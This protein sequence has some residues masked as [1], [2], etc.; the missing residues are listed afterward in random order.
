MDFAFQSDFDFSVW[1]PKWSFSVPQKWFVELRERFLDRWFATLGANKQ[2]KRLN[3]QVFELA[4]EATALRIGFNLSEAGSPKPFEMPISRPQT[5]AL[6]PAFYLSKDLGPVLYN[7]ADMDIESPVML[8]GNSDAL[9][10]SFTSTI[11][12][13][14][15]AVPTAKL[16]K[17]Q[18]E[19]IDRAFHERRYA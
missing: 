4:T 3:N 5:T 18:Y 6:S 7:L 16:V 8:S 12:N 17:E 14:Q 1:S 2:V 13:V 9:V 15:I 19:R 11:G 10:A